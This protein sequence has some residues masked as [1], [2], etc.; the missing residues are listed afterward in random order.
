MFGPGGQPQPE[1]GN[2][3]I[4]ASIRAPNATTGLVDMGSGS[5][6]VLVNQQYSGHKPEGMH[7]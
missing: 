1:L 5:Q 2:S 4:S 7:Q 3:F 6:K